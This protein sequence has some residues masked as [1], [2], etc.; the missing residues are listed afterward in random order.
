MKKV[1]IQIP[2]KVNLT[3]DILGV[4]DGYHQLESLVS[5]VS[6]YDTIILKKRKDNN[7]TFSAFGLNIG[8][9]EK[10]NNAYLAAK[11][12]MQTFNT[13]GV[14]IKLI[15][16][17][18][19][20]GGMG[21]SSADIVAVLI[22]MKKLFGVDCDLVPL[23]NKLGSDTAY[24]LNGGIKVISGRGEIIKDTAIKTPL[25]FTALKCDESISAGKCYSAFDGL[26]KNFAPCTKLAVEALEKGD[27]STF[28]TL[29]KNDLYHATASVVDKVDKNLFALKEAGAPLAI[30]TGSGTVVL[31]VYQDKKARDKHYAI[32]R[33]TH[34][35]KLLKFDTVNI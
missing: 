34:K 32:L 2:A 28:I 30:M 26:N 24:M 10:N 33:K 23:A 12:F 1:K 3:L 27:F 22:G 9:D 13:C 19:I 6:V 16:R 17:I 29:A 35:D 21:G 14:D 20:G 11:E 5:S 18:P 4:K 7:V 31:G 25:Y 15:K 8:T